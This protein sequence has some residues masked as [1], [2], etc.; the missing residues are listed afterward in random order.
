MSSAIRLGIV[1]SGV[2]LRHP[3]VGGIAGGV[4]VEADSFS[5]EFVD[6]IGHGTA[7]AALI[8]ALT[9]G[10]ALWAV[11]VFDRNLTTTMGRVLRA[12]DW[13]L[14][15]QMD[16]VNLSLG[17]L[18]PDHRLA[19]AAAVEKV[20]RAGAA[21][22][23]AFEMNGQPMLPGCMNGVIGV[24]A[25]PACARESYRCINRGGKQI[26]SASPYPLEIPGVRREH[27]LNGVSFAVAHISAKLANLRAAHGPTASW[28]ELL[29]S[30]AAR[31]ILSP[32]SPS[33]SHPTASAMGRRSY[34]ANR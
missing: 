21:L 30:D 23:S 34:P 32:P 12:V 28:P 29:A 26:F 4:A 22:V 15:N 9:P 27:N 2:H 6:R 24:I 11:R 8:H 7:I 13:C 1:D 19:F 16:I 14:E 3:H 18:N 33:T 31:P 17:T 10:A 20:K 25:D 5:E